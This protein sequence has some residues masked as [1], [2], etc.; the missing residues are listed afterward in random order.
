MKPKVTF[1]SIKWYLLMYRDMMTTNKMVIQSN[2]ERE[3]PTELLATQTD[4]NDSKNND[5]ILNNDNENIFNQLKKIYLP[6]LLN[7]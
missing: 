3:I 4:S 1:A 5:L 6:A 7:R 2:E